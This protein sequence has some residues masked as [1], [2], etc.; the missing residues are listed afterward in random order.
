MKKKKAVKKSGSR[1]ASVAG[2][3]LD[4]SDEDLFIMISPFGVTDIKGYLKQLDGLFKDIRLLAASVLSQ[5]EKDG[6]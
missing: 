3:Y 4:M 2:R 5:R 6:K 1:A